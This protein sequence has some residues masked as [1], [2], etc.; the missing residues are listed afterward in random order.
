MKVII[1]NKHPDEEPTQKIVL[2]AEGYD[3][4]FTQIWINGECYQLSVKGNG[5]VFNLKKY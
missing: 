4:K 3:W 2:E 5:R 1:T